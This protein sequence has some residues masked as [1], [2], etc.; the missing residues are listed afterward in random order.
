MALTLLESSFVMSSRNELINN[1]HLQ[2]LLVKHPYLGLLQKEHWCDYLDLL[3]QIYDHVEDIGQQAPYEGVRLLAYKF[4]RN[5]DLQSVESKVGQFFVMCIEELKVLKDFHDSNGRRMI[6]LTRPGR[7]LLQLVEE[8]LAQRVKFSSTGAETLLA[9]LNEALTYQQGFDKEAAIVHHRKK[10]KAYQVDLKRIEEKGPSHAEL[11]PLPHSIEAL[12]AQAEGAANDILSAVEDVKQAIESE[13]K[14]LAKNY[15]ESSL[16]SGQSVNAVAEFYEQLY[17]ANTHKSYIQA[18]DIFSQ[19]GSYGNLYPHK[20]ISKILSQLES[21]KKLPE[22]SLKRSPLKSF[23]KQ[24]FL[25]DTAIQEKI[26]SQIELLQ[27]QVRYSLSTDI[28]G[29]QSHLHDI[30]KCLFKHKKEAQN[31]F[32]KQPID[33]EVRELPLGEVQLFQ[34]ERPS[35]VDAMLVEESFEENDTMELIAALL[36]AEETTL[37]QIVN[38][39]NTLLKKERTLIL[40]NYPFEHGLAEYYVLIAIEL[41]NNE[42]EKKE[43]T[44]VDLNIQLKDKPFIIR[45]AQCFEYQSKES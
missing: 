5:K 34:F 35:E 29:L 10:I 1:N 38:R 18:K 12:F 2:S 14:L 41:F 15:M 26:K 6:E 45:N 3:T 27:L 25:A 39:F 43:L 31:F 9:A 44:P 33:F 4:F 20:N 36:K 19:F 21:D 22:E 23:Q 32:S 16:S 17:L 42:V 30:L 24:F 40:S 11:L 7:Q 37:K 8:L 13:R 28:K